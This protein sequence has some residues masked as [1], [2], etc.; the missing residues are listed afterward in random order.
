MPA[1]R[2]AFVRFLIA[3]V[4]LCGFSIAL[5]SAAS[6][7]NRHAVIVV[8]ATTTPALAKVAVQP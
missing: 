7:D 3:T 6:R 1:D 4:A 2:A 8:R 5:I